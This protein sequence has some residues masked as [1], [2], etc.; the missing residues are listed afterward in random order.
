M[1]QNLGKLW[2]IL[3]KLLSTRNKLSRYIVFHGA[4]INNTNRK[5]QILMNKPAYLGV[6]ILQSCS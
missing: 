6:S 1:M 2:E 4:S 3:E 5:S